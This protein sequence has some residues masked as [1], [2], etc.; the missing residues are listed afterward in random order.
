MKNVRSDFVATKGR[1]LANSELSAGSGATIVS[2]LL[3][4]IGTP[5]IKTD[6]QA[7]IRMQTVKSLQTSSPPAVS[8]GGSNLVPGFMFE[9]KNKVL[10]NVHGVIHALINR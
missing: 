8:G 10:D 7:D 9:S 6:S 1:N 2:Q 3:A 5:A 4:P